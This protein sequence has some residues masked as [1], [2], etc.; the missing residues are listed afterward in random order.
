[1]TEKK[2]LN[3]NDSPEVANDDNILGKD[4]DREKEIDELLD[5]RAVTPKAR[6]KRLL[7]FSN[8]KTT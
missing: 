5:L 1:M 7:Q 3:Q 6:K 2:P 4:Y 8:K